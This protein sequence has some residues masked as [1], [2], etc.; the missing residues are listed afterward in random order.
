LENVPVS[1]P[2][3]SIAQYGTIGRCRYGTTNHDH[4]SQ[5]IQAVSMAIGN[6]AI[7]IRAIIGTTATPPIRKTKKLSSS[8][9]FFSG[10]AIATPGFLLATPL[11]G[12]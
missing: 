9:Y 3:P 10:N 7:P 12:F 1:S 8:V 4:K 2:S 11:D 6:I 5:R